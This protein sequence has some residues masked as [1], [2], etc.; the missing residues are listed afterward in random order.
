MNAVARDLKLENGEIVQIGM[1]F[2]ALK[3]MMQYPGGFAR[4]QKSMTEGNENDPKTTMQAMDAFS[5][6]FWSLVRAGGTVCTKED[7]E[8]M[9]GLGD[10]PALTGVME[11]FA[12]SAQTMMPKNAAGRAHRKSILST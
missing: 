6:L 8:R 5:H 9:I 11:E 7:C 1:N 3:L 12:K 10:F 4:L 2:H